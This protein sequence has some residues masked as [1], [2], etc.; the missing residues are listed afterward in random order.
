MGWTWTGWI[1]DDGEGNGDDEE[2]EVQRQVQALPSAD[3]PEHKDG[4]GLVYW[5][6]A[7][8]DK[9]RSS[10]GLKDFKLVNEKSQ[11]AYIAQV[12]KEGKNG[13]GSGQKRFGASNEHWRWR[14]SHR[15]I[16]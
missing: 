8:L 15:S 4:K 16:Q 13:T 12:T 5:L 7:R 9:G 14:R 11:P 1:E 2:L 3:V 6:K 10:G